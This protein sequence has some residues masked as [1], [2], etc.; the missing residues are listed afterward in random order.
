MVVELSLPPDPRA[1]VIE[2]APTD[3]VLVDVQVADG[4][5]RT[6]SIRQGGVVTLDGGRPFSVRVTG[7]DGSG[8]ALEVPLPDIVLLVGEDLERAAT[9]APTGRAIDRPD[10]IESPAPA[11]GS[12]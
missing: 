3:P 4:K 7:P 12:S 10:L 6:E 5:I 9:S 2:A 1:E 8:V 11:T